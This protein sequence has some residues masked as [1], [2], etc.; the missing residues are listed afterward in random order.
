MAPSTVAVIGCGKATGTKVGFAIGHAHAE[1]WL[2]ADPTVRLVGV[3]PSP[4]N[5]AVFGQKFGLA[6]GDLFASTAAMYA[7]VA[8]DFVSVC[9]WAGL[10]AEQVIEAA[11]RGVRGVVCEKPMASD[12]GEMRRMVDACAASGV[13]LAIAHQRRYDPLFEAARTLIRDEAIGDG[14]VLEA[15][16]TDDWD[17]LEWT[18]HWFDMANYLLDAAPLT[19]LAGIGHSGHRRYG[20]AIEDRS[21]AF[22]EYP[23]G[24]QA[25]FVT[26]PANPPGDDIV[27]RGSEGVLRIGSTLKVLTDHGVTIH[28][29][30]P[31]AISPFGALMSDVLRVAGTAESMPCGVELC[32]VATEVAFAAQESAR[33]MR[34]VALPLTTWFAPL[35]IVQR[36]PRLALPRGRV[37]ILADDH[38]GSG[39]REGLAEAIDALTGDAPLVL[40]AT[41]PLEASVLSDAAVLLI[42]HTQAEADAETQRLLT[43]WV[44]RDK[45]MILVHAALGAWPQWDAYGR[46]AC[47]VWT[48]GPGGSEHPLEPAELRVLPDTSYHPP[49]EVAWLPNDEVYTRLQSTDRA[50]DLVTATIPQGSFPAAWTSAAHPG[51]GA[52]MPGHRRDSWSVPAMREGLAH[53][54]R[55]CASGTAVS[56]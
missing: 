9:T 56:R 47:R 24:R 46:W 8:P 18:V 48:W 52:W 1:G 19:V 11:G 31:A 26:G 34:T 37:V 29:P 49:W 25:I 13:R 53:L 20:H 6:P 22:V 2:T 16:V 30:Q 32:G 44:G 5:L 28:E 35:E 3:D 42:Y 55:S 7:A 4:E 27:V 51:V 40:D 36:S 10:H 15:R 12:V 33:T 50:I 23:A 54:I 17:M 14:L 41:R 21:I 38:F 45:A 43:D 39:G